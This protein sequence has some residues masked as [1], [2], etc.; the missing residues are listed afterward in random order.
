M[1]YDIYCDESRRDILVKI[2]KS[3][4]WKVNKIKIT[5]YLAHWLMPLQIPNYK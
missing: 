2:G 1:L 3:L 5:G 4:K